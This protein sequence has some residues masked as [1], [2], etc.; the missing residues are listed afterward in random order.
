M[1]DIDPEERESILEDLED[2][3]AMRAVFEPRGYKG[4]VIVCSECGED[5]YYE[6]EMLKESLEHMLETGEPRM[7]EPAF[8]PSPDEYVGW[9]YARGYLDAITE[10]DADEM[11][12]PPEPPIPEASAWLG[13]RTRCAYCRG[14]LPSKAWAEWSYCP[15]CQASLA[16]LRLVDQLASRGWDE[17]DIVALMDQCGFEPP[18]EKG[19]EA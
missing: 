13:D 2:L 7:H 1:S 9:D 10:A 5:H 16:P 4:V 17:D 12:P 6:W 14:R 11:E 15:F 18:L 19:E 8:E 3:E